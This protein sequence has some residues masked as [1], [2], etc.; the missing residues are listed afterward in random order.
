MG[1][2]KTSESLSGQ[3]LQQK[4]LLVGD[5]ILDKTIIGQPK[6]I[7]PEAPIVVWSE[8][9]TSISPG[10]AGNVMMNLVRM[11]K[12]LGG[13]TI[14]FAGPLSKEVKNLFSENLEDNEYTTHVEQRKTSVKNRIISLDAVHRVRFDEDQRDEL[15]REDIDATISEIK[16]DSWDIGVISDYAHGAIT[17][18]IFLAARENCKTLIVDP[19]NEDYSIYLG[20]DYITPNLAEVLTLVPRSKD[21]L[22]AAK[23]LSKL[24]SCSV[25]LKQGRDGCSLFGYKKKIVVTYPPHQVNT[26]DVTGAGDTFISTLAIAL[27]KNIPINLAIEKANMMAAISTTQKMCFVPTEQQVSELFSK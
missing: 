23:K 20:C 26:I 27:A 15:A 18:D 13:V 1:N 7:S 25:I 21:P 22:A 12:V 8:I 2:K 17:R 16:K 10:G 6:G 24:L 4:I 14:F 19:K 9:H 5:C 3:N 11:A